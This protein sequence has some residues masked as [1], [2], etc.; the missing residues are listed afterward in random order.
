MLSLLF[1]FGAAHYDQVDASFRKEAADVA[2]ST[3]DQKTAHDVFAQHKSRLGRATYLVAP[4]ASSPGAVRHIQQHQQE[5]SSHDVHA[6]DADDRGMQIAPAAIQSSA[7]TAAAAAEGLTRRHPAP[8][9]EGASTSG[10]GKPTPEGADE[11]VKARQHVKLGEWP[12]T[13]ICANDITS[14][15]FYAVSI[16]T[17]SAGIWA[18]LCF[19]F[20]VFV[21]YL[22][23]NVYGEAVT[24]LPLNGGA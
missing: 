3:M 18:P 1:R 22:F 9:A 13:A 5:T 23:R 7:T 6:G 21:L 24:A 11:H 16:T 19:L 10:L 14:S 12:A 15:C 17:Q 20:V 8:S 4:A 2:V